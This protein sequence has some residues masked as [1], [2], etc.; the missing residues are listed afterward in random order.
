MVEDGVHSSGATDSEAVGVSVAEHSWLVA[1]ADEVAA[2]HLIVDEID[3]L[4]VADAE[5]VAD[6]LIV[7]AVGVLE[8]LDSGSF[9]DAVAKEGALS[10]AAS[11]AVVIE[12]CVQIAAFLR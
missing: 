5:V 4:I 1:A 11:A 3:H 8:V 12:N 9:D 10:A 6:H 2:D 7:V